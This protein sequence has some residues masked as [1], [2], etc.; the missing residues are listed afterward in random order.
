MKQAIVT[1]A[2]GF[3]GRWL[4]RALTEDGIETTAVIRVGSSKKNILPAGE[5]LSVVECD[6]ESYSMLPQ[7]LPKQPDCV[8]YH[9]AWNGVSG[10]ARGDMEV[11]FQNIRGS[12]AAVEAAQALG[13]VK[14]IGLGSIMEKEAELAAG[15]DGVQPGIGYIYGEAK[16]FAHLL[17][18]AAA[19]QTGIAHLW[20]LLT[21]AYG[22]LDDSPRFIHTTLQ[23]ILQGEPLTF[24][25]GTQIYDFIH[26]EDAAKALVAIGK[27]GRAFSSYLIGGG[28]PRPLREFVEEL[29]KTVAPERELHFGAIPYS[30]AQVPVEVFSID[31]LTEDTGFR[32]VISFSEGIV[33]TFNWMKKAKAEGGE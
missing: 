10:S 31:R 3:I 13:C 23:K 33:R 25:A 7:M 24:T 28:T 6:M 5:K 17:T 11:Q 16:H 32:P 8:F 4:L 20:P 1:G 12:K 21:N 26:V 30:G 22:E 2:T 19:A 29:G 18:K 9:L 27:Y 14:F 15:A